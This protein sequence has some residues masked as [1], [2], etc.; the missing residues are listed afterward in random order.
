M[1]VDENP[2]QEFNTNQRAAFCVYSGKGID[3]LR[4]YLADLM[5]NVQADFTD[6]TETD[7]DEEGE[8]EFRS[9]SEADEQPDDAPAPETLQT[10]RGVVVAPQSWSSWI[11]HRQRQNPFEEGSST[12]NEEGSGPET[13]R[14]SE[15]D[16]GRYSA[17]SIRPVPSTVVTIRGRAGRAI[18]E[19]G[20]GSTPEVRPPLVEENTNPSSLAT[21]PSPTVL[22]TPDGTPSNTI[23]ERPRGFGTDLIVEAPTP[24]PQITPF[25]SQR[26]ARDNASSPMPTYERANSIASDELSNRSVQSSGT[27]TSLSNGAG[28]FRS[29]NSNAIVASNGHSGPASDSGSAHGGTYTP[30]LIFAEIGHGRGRDTAPGPSAIQHSLSYMRSSS[31]P[32]AGSTATRSKSDYIASN[33]SDPFLPSTSTS[34]SLAARNARSR[35][36]TIL[37]PRG[38]GPVEE[39]APSSPIPYL[40]HS[41]TRELQE[42]VH[43]ALTGSRGSHP[44]P[45]HARNQTHAQSRTSTNPAS[46]TS[47]LI[48]DETDTRGRLARRS[49]KSTFSSVAEHYA[50]ALFFRDRANSGSSSNGAGPTASASTGDVGS[51]SA[52]PRGRTGS[53][54]GWNRFG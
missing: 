46:S 43:N 22:P 19:R 16:N 27:N 32:E 15:D 3:N 1:Y 41:P 31:F 2:C 29:Y 30:D 17:E 54:N 52:R 53:F 28:F 37:A 9:S 42:S 51:S 11:T 39:H 13:A 21:T 45:S 35:D 36:D 38:Q 10:P 8:E 47:A 50:N 48:Q 26:T 25:A 23:T 12:V 44:F 7:Y 14:R 4:T 24:S 49:L 40:S 20:R 5:A 6:E 33:G 34:T 18:T